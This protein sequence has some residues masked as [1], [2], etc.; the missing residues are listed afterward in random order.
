MQNITKHHKTSLKTK[1]KHSPDESYYGMATNHTQEALHLCFSL[2]LQWC[3][4]DYWYCK[5]RYH[6]I[7]YVLLSR[8]YTI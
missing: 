4:L 8:H 5:H 3:M 6:R 2:L 1:V 7:L